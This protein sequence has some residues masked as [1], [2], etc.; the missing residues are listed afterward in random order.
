MWMNASPLI[1]FA[2]HCEL[3]VT[4]LMVLMS[5]AASLVFK[6]MESI[7]HVR[8]CYCIVRQSLAV[9]LKGVPI[10]R[11]IRSFSYLYSKKLNRF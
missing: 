10:R 1:T 8:I 3:S 5:V 4:T 11:D 9:C 7:V 2:T 6:A